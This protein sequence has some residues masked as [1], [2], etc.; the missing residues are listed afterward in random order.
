MSSRKASVIDVVI[1]GKDKDMKHKMFQRLELNSSIA[2][3]QDFWR[4]HIGEKNLTDSLKARNSW[5]IRD[6]PECHQGMGCWGW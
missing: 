2:P 4:A 6:V 5:P 3:A 1:V